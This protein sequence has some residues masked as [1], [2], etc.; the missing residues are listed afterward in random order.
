MA[1]N[2]DDEPVSRTAQYMREWREKNPDKWRAYMQEWRAAN[3]DRL[4][5]SNRAWREANREELLEKKRQWARENRAKASRWRRDNPELAR[6]RA[7]QNQAAWRLRQR[8]DKLAWEFNNPAIVAAKAAD[9]K[10]KALD[11]A[12]RWKAA[13]PELAIATS[14]ANLAKRRYPNTGEL[15]GA[16][17]LEV[18]RRAGGKCHW[19]GKE[20]LKGRDL[21]L[22][23]LQ[24]VNQI[25][26]LTIACARCNCAKLANTKD[27]H[28]R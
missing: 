2:T 13:N 14:K 24:P 15:D 23:H 21:T 16:M 19:C 9:R 28:A 25:E 6:E 26:H 27:P 11:R 3:K 7:R 10:K 18:I 5:E 17:V 22:E 1:N 4:R 20:N 8:A 12:A